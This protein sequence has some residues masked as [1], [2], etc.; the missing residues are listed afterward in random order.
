V[1][2]KWQEDHGSERVKRCESP[3][4]EDHAK[5]HDRGDAEEG[6]QYHLKPTRHSTIR[7][8][9]RPT[10]SLPSVMPVMMNADKNGPTKE[11]MAM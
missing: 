7:C 3:W 2:L 6:E 9:K 11:A 4:Q 1:L 5:H 8:T 10:P